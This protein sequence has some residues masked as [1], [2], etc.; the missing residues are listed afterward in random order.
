MLYVFAFVCFL[1]FMVLHSTIWG[2]I[3]WE[4]PVFLFLCACSQVH[5][6]MQIINTLEIKMMLTEVNEVLKWSLYALS[7][8]EFEILYSIYNIGMEG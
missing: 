6:N 3:I 5:G 1:H 7:V 8:L 2:T 4:L